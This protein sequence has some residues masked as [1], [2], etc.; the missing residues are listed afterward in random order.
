MYI[1]IFLFVVEAPAIV[2]M[3]FFAVLLALAAGPAVVQ[4][5]MGLDHG[6]ILRTGCRIS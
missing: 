4:P 6:C 1:V 5:L 3:L 2:H